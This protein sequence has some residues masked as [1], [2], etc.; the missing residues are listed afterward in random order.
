MIVRVYKDV[1]VDDSE[2]ENY[3]EVAIE[4]ATESL[5]D[6]DVE[7]IEETEK[8]KTINEYF[9]ECLRRWSRHGK[10]Q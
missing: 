1:D 5:S 4:V 2:E 3:K 9:D 6:F 7:I 10:R 8:P